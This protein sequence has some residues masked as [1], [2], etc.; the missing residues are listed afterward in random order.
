V[1]ATTPPH[2]FHIIALKFIPIKF[3]VIMGPLLLFLSNFHD[4]FLL[5]P[6]SFKVCKFSSRHQLWTCIIPGLNYS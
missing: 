6:R 2:G 4:N 1:L 5:K 3:E